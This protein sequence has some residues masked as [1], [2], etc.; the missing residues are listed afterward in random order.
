LILD[1]QSAERQ[2][3]I[4]RRQVDEEKERYN[5]LEQEIENERELK[6]LADLQL[7]NLENERSNFK[8]E[9]IRLTG[10]ISNIESTMKVG[11]TPAK[12]ID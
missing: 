8:S 6:R 1:L 11:T 7:Q 9:I 12:T 3:E 4:L 10:R 5:E 2:I